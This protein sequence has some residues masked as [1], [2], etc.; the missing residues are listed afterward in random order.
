MCIDSNLGVSNSKKNLAK[1]IGWKSFQRTKKNGKVEL[2]S[3][4]FAT[5]RLPIGR[6]IDAI[7]YDR[8]PKRKTIDGSCGRRYRKGWHI[9]LKQPDTEIYTRK[10]RFRL[11]VAI[12]HQSGI[13]GLVAVAQQMLIIPKK[14]RMSK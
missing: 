12:G 11:P 2:K 13:L 1:G 10:V 9:Y 3:S 14:K 6:W 8:S 7:N 5:R 4:I